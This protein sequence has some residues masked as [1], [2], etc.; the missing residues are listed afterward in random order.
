MF[1][2]SFSWLL[3]DT[4]YLKVN[5]Y[6]DHKFNVSVN[7][8]IKQSFFTGIR[9]KTKNKKKLIFTV[10]CIWSRD[11]VLEFVR[12]QY[13]IGD[14]VFHVLYK[15]KQCRVFHSNFIIHVYMYMSFC[16]CILCIYLFVELYLSEE[17]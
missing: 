16:E 2:L 14:V 10:N 3:D 5:V 13:N 7:P 11:I 12:R 4:R 17:S 6:S 8:N 1:F 15:L 9:K